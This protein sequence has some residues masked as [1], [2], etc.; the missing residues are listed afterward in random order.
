MESKGK[1][2]HTLR[3]PNEVVVHCLQG[4]QNK[5]LLPFSTKANSKFYQHPQH[6]SSALHRYINER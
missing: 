4:I 6:P 2:C 1:E 3:D 5:Q